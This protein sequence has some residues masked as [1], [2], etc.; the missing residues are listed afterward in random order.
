MASI[1]PYTT[2]AGEERY[3]VSVFV[4][5]DDLTGKPRY[6][7]RSGFSSKKEATLAASRLTL[8]A[9]NGD[10]TKTKRLHFKDVY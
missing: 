8:D 7:H 5:R 10:L 1:K 3:E 2:K 6:I 9:A 4:G